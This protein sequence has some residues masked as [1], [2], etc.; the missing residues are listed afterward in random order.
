MNFWR[1]F[2]RNCLRRDSYRS[3]PVN[4]DIKNETALK[5]E[6]LKKGNN[7]KPHKKRVNGV[8]ALLNCS[9]LTVL[10]TFFKLSL[11]EKGE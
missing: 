9:F 2:P 6:T 11:V 3:Q 1:E 4:Q 7:M 8:K 10:D 5:M